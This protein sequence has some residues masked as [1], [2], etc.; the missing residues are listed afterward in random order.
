MAAKNSS[1]NSF[2][3]WYFSRSPSNS[4]VFVGSAASRT[5]F[6]SA[7]RTG[8]CGG[9]AFMPTYWGD[10]F[11]MILNL[12]PAYFYGNWRRRSQTFCRDEKIYRQS[13]GDPVDLTGGEKAILPAWILRNTKGDLPGLFRARSE[14]YSVDNPRLFVR[15]RVPITLARGQEREFQCPGGG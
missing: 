13:E 8:L 2:R 15:S 4:A 3:C 12:P 9:I 10:R 1:A 11:L 5:R 6:R 7:G 14:V